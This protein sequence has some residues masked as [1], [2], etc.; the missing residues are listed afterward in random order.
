MGNRLLLAIHWLV[1]VSSVI[2]IGGYAIAFYQN[3]TTPHPTYTTVANPNYNSEKCRSSRRPALPQQREILTFAD[4]MNC[5]PTFKKPSGP[6]KPP[7]PEGW[8]ILVGLLLL[9]TFAVIAWI[10]QGRWIWFPW[11]RDD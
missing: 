4:I 11:Q 2:L 6:K 9:P 10:T 1:F 7:M 3:V 5:D 8:V